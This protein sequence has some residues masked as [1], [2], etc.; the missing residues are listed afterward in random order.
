MCLTFWERCFA[1]WRNLT[2][3]GEGKLKAEHRDA[4]GL[5]S[6]L[7]LYDRGVC[8]RQELITK[9]ER[10]IVTPMLPQITFPRCAQA[11]IYRPTERED[12]QLDE[13]GAD[14]S[15]SNR[16]LRISS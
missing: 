7:C 10:A 9:G 11:S 4:R 5:G 14:C 8:S 2:T 16:G 13:M 3:L 15:G 6:H 1:A 12:E